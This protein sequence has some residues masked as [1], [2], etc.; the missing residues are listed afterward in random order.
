MSNLLDSHLRR[1][2][3][4]NF[5]EQTLVRD[6]SKIENHIR[7]HLGTMP[8]TDITEDDLLDYFE[9]LKAKRRTRRRR[10]HGQL[11]EVDEPLLGPSPLRDIHGILNQVFK[12]AESPR[13]C[14]RLV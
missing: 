7:P 13:V 12:D 1:R 5:D 8:V 6:R 9:L 2:T 10:V 3:T 4:D 14:W 11:V